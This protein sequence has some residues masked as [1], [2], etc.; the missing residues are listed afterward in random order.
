MSSSSTITRKSPGN[1]KERGD[2]GWA[3][4]G[5]SG[6]GM[7]DGYERWGAVCVEV[8]MGWTHEKQS[9]GWAAAWEGERG[10]LQEELLYPLHNEGLLGS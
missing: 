3:G 7:Q 9:R 2:G 8:R 1:G 4:G 10:G 6:V 5:A